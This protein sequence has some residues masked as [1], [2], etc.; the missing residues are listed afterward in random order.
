MNVGSSF[1][2]NPQ[3]AKLVEPGQGSLHYP[4]IDAQP[5]PMLRGASGQDGPDPQQA[6]RLPMNCR[7]IGPVSLDLVWPT[8]R[9]TRLAPHWRNGGHQ[10]QQLGH[11]M[12]ISSSQQSRQGNPLSI[13]NDMMFTPQ[14][15]LVR[16]V[17][18]SFFPH[19]PPLGGKHCPPGPVTNQSHPLLVVG[20]AAIHAAAARPQL[21]ANS[22]G[23][24]S[25]SC[26]SHRPSPREC[27]S[28]ERRGCQ[29]GPVGRP[30]ACDQGSP[31][32]WAWLVA[33]GV[34]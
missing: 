3:P 4:P 14:L 33:A 6:Q 11:I 25:R 10:G 15:A 21:P 9:T 19:H 1:I 7:V 20:P 22:A 16:G 28:S 34:E 13:G 27:R 31:G 24:A 23:D 5:T 8:P 29:S 30:K 17:G 32:V 18:A 26:P 12:T 2:T